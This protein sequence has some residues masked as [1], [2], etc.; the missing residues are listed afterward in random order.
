MKSL[1]PLI[2]SKTLL[3]AYS[4]A[5]FNCAQNDTVLS[6]CFCHVDS[7][8]ADIIISFILA[9]IY[10]SDHFF[11]CIKIHVQLQA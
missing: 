7:I 2:N 4:K 1:H 5:A 8:N 10:S 9:F 3:F 6:R 11:N